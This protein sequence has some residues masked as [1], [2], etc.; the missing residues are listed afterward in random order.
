MTPLILAVLVR[1]ASAQEDPHLSVV[2]PADAGMSARRLD[3]IN[4][5]VAEGLAQNKT[6]GCVVVVGYQG[7]IVHRRAYGQRQV[8]PQ[9]EPM[10]PDTIF[11]LAS[12][13]KP[14]ATATSV[15]LL[16]EEGRVQLDDPISR[17][18]PEFAQAGKEA[19]TIEHLLTHQ[20]GLIADNPLRDYLDGPEH[21]W[22]RICALEPLTEP[23]ERFIYSDVGFI[24]L[25]KLVERVT[26]QSLDDWTQQRLFGPL[27]LRDT[28][29]LPREELHARCA[30]TEL[31]GDAWLRGTVHDPRAR[32]LGGIA[33]HAG[34]FST[35]DDLGIFV[36]MLL[37]GGT[38]AGVRILKP[39]TVQMMHSPH[40]TSGGIR[41]LGWDMHSVYSSNR[42]TSS[43]RVP[44]DMAASPGQRSGSTRSRSC[45]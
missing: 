33:G 45:S 36:Q 24:V 26:G 28:S 6:P 4:H 35:A 9:P 30:P 32:E 25:G 13:T 3:V 41:G 42:G 21:A 31:Q 20:G 43:A 38:Y 7:H 8:E 34:L 19:I 27:Q 39:E 23:G 37:D 11:D 17:H 14:I 18:L 15:L 12:L 29:Y 2:D 1:L 5:V 10:T 44:L 22:E 16:L 40:E